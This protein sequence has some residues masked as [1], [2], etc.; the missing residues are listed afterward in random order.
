MKKILI[1]TD[2][3]DNAWDALTYAI[4]MYDDIPCRFYILNTFE[5]VASGTNTTLHS[6]ATKKIVAILK[7]DSQRGLT[8][9]ENYLNEYLLND[10]HE[11]E[12]I[13]KYGSLTTKV[14]EI[15]DQKGIDLVVMGTAGASGLKK[16]FIGSNT[17]RLIKQGQA[18]PIIA[19]PKDFEFVEPSLISFASDLK[20]QFTPG[21][22]TPLRELLLIHDLDLEILHVNKNKELSEIQ[23]QNIATIK[24]LLGS[25]NI[26]YKEIDYETSVAKSINNYTDKNKV[27]IICLVHYDH[28]FVEKLTHEPVLQKV[29]FHSKVPLLILSI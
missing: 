28:T 13:S 7:E 27:D 6:G 4:R 8:K 16:V 22:L 20:R 26:N 5:V 11:Y 2:F 3:S 21:D 19:V 14:K 17:V 29:G 18:C 9:I 23:H 10:K 15:I 12:T 25:N 1:P 24:S